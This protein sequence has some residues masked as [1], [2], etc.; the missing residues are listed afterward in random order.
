ML[1]AMAGGLLVCTAAFVNGGPILFPDTLSYLSDGTNLVRLSRPINERS[2]SYG[3]MIWPLHGERT[4]WPVVLAQGLVVAH[5]LRLALRVMGVDA[6]TP[7]FLAIVAALALATPLSWH[8]SHVLPDVFAG[9][10]VLALFLLGFAAHRLGRGEVAYLVLLAATAISFHLSHLPT[11]LAI[12]GATMLSWAIGHWRRG[13]RATADADATAA[14]AAAAARVDPRPLLVIAPVALA[15]AGLLAFS[16]AV[17]GFAS[18]TPRSPPFAVARLLADG[19]AKAW[20]REVCPQ[21]RLALCPHLDTI[22]DN[23]IAIVWGFFHERRRTPEYARMRAEQGEVVLGTLLRFP[24]EVIGNALSATAWQLATIESEAQFNDADR[25]KLPARYP[26]ADAA[27]EGSMQDRGLL[28]KPSLAHVNRVHGWVAL[29][30]AIGAAVSAILCARRRQWLPALFT[31]VVALAL[32][33]NAFTTGTLSG[34]Y[35][36]Y[37]GRLIWLLTLCAIVG[38]WRWAASGRHARRGGPSHAA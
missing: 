1:V 23:E 26:Y 33:A 37:Q 7:A 4:L 9:V 3:L 35:G 2:V 13:S 28:S 30:S 11:A 38:W 10:S 6:R 18:L 5:L 17:Y 19:P 24:R 16:L 29:S 15:V 22:P 8:A 32:L 27:F 20:L 14:A 21:R 36:R 12:V 25:W 34:V 31:A